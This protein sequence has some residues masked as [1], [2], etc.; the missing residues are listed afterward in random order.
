MQTVKLFPF[1]PK[2][3]IEQKSSLVLYV[4][5]FPYKLKRK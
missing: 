4:K 3:D 2:N 5:F 1:P